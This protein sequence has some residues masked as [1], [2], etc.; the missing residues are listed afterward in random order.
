MR[1]AARVLQKEFPDFDP[2]SMDPDPCQVCVGASAL[3]EVHT[4][5][6]REIQQ[7]EKVSFLS[8]FALGLS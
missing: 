3:N 8:S 1:Q 7:K 5:Q 4:Q 6:L 2:T